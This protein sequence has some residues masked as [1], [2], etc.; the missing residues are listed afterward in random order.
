MTND[1]QRQT[2]ILTVAL[3][4]FSALRDEI[5]NRN[6]SAFTMIN[7]NIT[8]TAT[9]AGFVLSNNADPLILLLLPILSPSLGLLYIDHVINILNIGDYIN[10]EIKPLIAATVNCDGVLNYETRVDQYETNKFMRF[11]PVGLPLTIM[12]SAIPLVALIFV[13]TYLNQ[14]WSWLLWLLG[15]FMVVS[16]VLLWLDF[17]MR[18]YR[19]NA[20]SGHKERRGRVR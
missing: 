5:S 2:E 14:Y 19:T 15:L 20:K 3:A 4:E 16:F 8:A 7:L 9:V 11:L 1:E 12:F 10:K 13:R 6:N 18:P 17:L